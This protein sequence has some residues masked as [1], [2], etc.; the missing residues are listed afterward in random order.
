MCLILC[1]RDNFYYFADTEK[2]RVIGLEIEHAVKFSQVN[3]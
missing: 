2:Q 3:N 1:E